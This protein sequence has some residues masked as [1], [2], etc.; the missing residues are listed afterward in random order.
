MCSNV[1]E[2]FNSWIRKARNLP[3]IRMVDSIL[4]KIMRQMFKRRVASHS[5]TG[6]ICPKMESYL[7]KAF[8]KGK[9]WTV[10]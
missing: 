6:A 1:A 5:W 3:I 8:N 2:S 4:A 9:S 10:I 7:E